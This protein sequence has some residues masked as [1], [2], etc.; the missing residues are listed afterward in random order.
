MLSCP[1]RPSYVCKIHEFKKEE[2]I[3]I[4]SDLADSREEIGRQS[5]DECGKCGG[6][7][8]E[9]MRLTSQKCILIVIWLLSLQ[10]LGDT[11]GIISILN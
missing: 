3:I 1:F 9:V 10:F 11:F 2:N 6:T 7:R 8:I 4:P 5:L